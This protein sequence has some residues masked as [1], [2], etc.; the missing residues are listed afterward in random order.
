[1]RCM[2]NIS[3]TEHLFL[4]GEIQVGKSTLLHRYLAEK[5]CRV[6][7]FHTVWRDSEHRTLHLLPYAGGICLAENCIAERVSGKLTPH[8]EVF[9]RIG[10]ALL[11]LP[12]DILVMDEL[13][14]L[15]SESYGFQAAVLTALNS[16]TPIVGVIKPRHTDFLDKVRS[17]RCVRI[18]EVTI[19]NRNAL[20]LF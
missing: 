3:M 12:C 20:F 17:H 8:P 4:T 11:D 15:E 6:G 13:G 14:F 2:R 9:D 5:D 10:P 1:M 7:G 19:E 18:V 16:N